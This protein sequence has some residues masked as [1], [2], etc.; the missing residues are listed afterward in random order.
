MVL[1]TLYSFH[2]CF[3]VS[4]ITER[5]E[6]SVDIALGDGFGWASA[7]ANAPT[8]DRSERSPFEGSLASPSQ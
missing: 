6:V 2:L 1:R 5:A 7:S 4:S 8:A 3:E